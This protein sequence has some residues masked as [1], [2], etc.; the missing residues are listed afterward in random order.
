ML[1]PANKYVNQNSLYCN[2]SLPNSC[3]TI[4]SVVWHISGVALVTYLGQFYGVHVMWIG[5]SGA[6]EIDVVLH[7][8]RQVTLGNAFVRC[9]QDK[10]CQGKRIFVYL[11]LFYTWAPNLWV[12]LIVQSRC[13]MVSMV[14]AVAKRWRKVYHR[15]FTVVMTYLPNTLWAWE[16]FSRQICNFL[17]QTEVLKPVK[18]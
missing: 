3:V 8:W 6:R 17:T 2:A 11:C 18:K 5:L 4:T 10:F 16:L 9:P 1:R 13:D 12:K 14:A 15:W 7:T